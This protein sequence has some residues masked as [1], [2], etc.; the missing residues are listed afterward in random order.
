MIKH[1]LQQKEKWGGCERKWGNEEEMKDKRV[2][3]M[4]VT[5]QSETVKYVWEREIEREEK[6]ENERH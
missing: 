6:I 5:R 4:K 1:L 3:E 2:E